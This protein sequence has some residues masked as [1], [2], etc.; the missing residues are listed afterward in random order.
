MNALTLYTSPASR[1]RIVRWMLEEI[2]VP[3]NVTVLAPGVSATDTT[4][5]GINPMGKVPALVH[6]DTVVTETAAICM[7]LADQ[8]PDAGL[9]PAHHLRGAYYRWFC[10]ATGPLE[11]AMTNQ[12]LGFVV[13]AELTASVGY[14]RF[15]QV[16]DVLETVLAQQPYMTDDEFS[17]VD[18]YLGSQLGL[19][20]Q[21]GAIEQR[22]AFKRYWQQLSERPA[23]IRAQALEA[24]L[25]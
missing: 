4:Y 8:F 19:G 14:G 3:Y 18:V 23:C 17:A 24:E 21:F 7:Y 9:A 10:F 11:A 2:G 16:L 20:M 13:P 22:P 15:E 12:M 1:G 6:G 5:L 25:E